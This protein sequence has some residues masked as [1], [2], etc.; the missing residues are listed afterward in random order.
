MTPPRL[1]LVNGN[2]ELLT[3]AVAGAGALEALLGVSVADDWSGFPEALPILCSSYT[4]NPEGQAWGSLF[5]VEPEVRTLVGFGG[6]KGPPSSD[7]VVEIG[8]AIAPAFQGRGLASDAVAQMVQRAFEDASVRAVDA[9]TLGHANP[10]TRVLEK[11]G[12]RKIGETND[13]DEGSV[14]HWRRERPA[15]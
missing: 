2:L 15:R 9:H 6:F 11:S 3:A 14:W 1:K 12:F 13:P 10:S 7:A 8:Y 4:K 5:F